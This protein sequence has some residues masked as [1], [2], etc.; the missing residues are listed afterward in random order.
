MKF[1]KFCHTVCDTGKIFWKIFCEFLNEYFFLFIFC[2]DV[3]NFIINRGVSKVFLLMFIESFRYNFRSP[4]S[5]TNN[6]FFDFQC[7]V[8][9]YLENKLV[10]K[11]NVW[12]GKKIKSTR[13]C[14]VV[15]INTLTKK[16]C[17]ESTINLLCIAEGMF[18]SF[19]LVRSK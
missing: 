15:F 19:R 3:K 18:S 13:K 17:F 7:S 5:H 9:K 2:K 4:F 10:I 14:S 12:Q 1:P 6:K 16:R 11:L 8:C